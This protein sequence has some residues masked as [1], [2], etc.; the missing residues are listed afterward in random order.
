MKILAT[1]VANGVA[2]WVASALVSGIEFGGQGWSTVLT[3]VLVAAVFGVVNAV[4]RPLAQLLSLPFI[5]LTLG[6]FLVVVNAL[7]LL[8]TSWL[9]GV[10]GLDFRV[11]DFWWDAVLGAVIVSAVSMVVGMLLPDGRD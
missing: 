8:L 5:L 7:M 3:V 9:A 4:V 11:D 2:L 6:L 10:L 1:V